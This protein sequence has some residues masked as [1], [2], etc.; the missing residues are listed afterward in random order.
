MC[1]GYRNSL[2]KNCQDI[3]SP[4][5]SFADTTIE[6]YWVHITVVSVGRDECVCYQKAKTSSL[7]QNFVSVMDISL[8]MPNFIG[9]LLESRWI[10]ISDIR[11]DV[12]IINVP[13]ETQ[14][15]SNA[16]HIN[17]LMLS[18]GFWRQQLKAFQSCKWTQ[19]LAG[20]AAKA[21]S[22]QSWQKCN[23]SSSN[24]PNHAWQKTEWN[25]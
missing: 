20:I 21:C 6:M 16:H 14:Q 22:V 9:F 23:I 8:V 19:I 12:A 4:S 11:T 13:L 10:L 2:Q 15:I 24:W 1:F 3:N 25:N 17:C 7:T 18:N 5:L